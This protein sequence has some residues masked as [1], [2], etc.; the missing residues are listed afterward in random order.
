MK[1][2]IWATSPVFYGIV[3]VMLLMALL[4]RF[5]DARIFYAELVLAV[6]AFA[7]V[8]M[9]NHHFKLY[10]GT[11]VKSAEKILSASDYRALHEFSIPAVLVGKM[12]DVI[13][14]NS[15]FSSEVS[16]GFDCRGENVARFLTPHTL[17]QAVGGEGIDTQVGQRQY[18]VYSM[19][20]RNGYV[21]YFVDNTYYKEISR[22]YSDQKPVV[23]LV[24]FD[25]REELI[26]DSASSEDAR[27]SAA[28]EEV[29]RNWTKDTGSFLERLAGGRYLIMTDEVHI[30]EDVKKRFEVIDAVRTVKSAD[31]RSATIS[32]GVGR[33][34]PTFAEGEL[35]ARQAL[36]MALGRG[37][38][39]VAVKQEDGTYEFFGGLSKGVEKRDKVR[40]RVIAATLSDHVKECDIVFIMGHKFSDLDAIGAAVG[41][42]S[43]VHK[44]LG[45]QAYIVVNRAQ[46]MA[47][48]I[49]ES[50]EQSMPDEKIFI[51]PDE[52]LD[53]VTQ[54]SLLIVVDTHSQD[55]VES[56]ELLRQTPK[57]VVID[58]HRMMV[59]HIS[60]AIVFYHEP[61]ASSAAEL[62]TEL[63][64]YISEK[65]LS[66]VEA[67]ALLAGIMLDT[68]NF[69]LKT[70]VRTFE[71][72]A[73][74]RRRGADTVEVKRLFSNT[75]DTYKAKYQM[76]SSAEIYNNCA[77]VSADEETPDIRVAA[78]QA[79]DELLSIQGVN[80]SFV[81]YPT[82]GGVQI[83][84]R[85]L[86]DVNV[87]VIMEVMGGGGHLTMAAV[88]LK[89]TTLQQARDT[90]ISVINNNLAKASKPSLPAQGGTNK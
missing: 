84:A 26:R 77:I 56:E 9:A 70:G 43:A 79:A 14:Y 62:V 58:H 44:G 36:D 83:S 29:L 57:V 18:T 39:Q 61:Y 4:S 8:A 1:R 21:L 42:W 89:N 38:D 25:N 35:W 46:S 12:G 32:I 23:A 22:R 3:A 5:W 82:P 76:V 7:A 69:V 34:A 80:A 30:R 66:R 6:L 64:Q 27:I 28:V 81:I 78:A 75:I 41:M 15:R 40:T 51:T 60:N 71:A 85:S 86:G 65:A 73:Y 13:W 72:A 24:L 52:A 45:K 2:K 74:L 55:F 53:L 37:G 88:Q 68:K 20:T 17:E 87:Q 47:V 90:L 50:M 16:P 19:S 31:N 54:K 59:K 63:V 67:E 49:I 48:P 33:G 11:A 10:V